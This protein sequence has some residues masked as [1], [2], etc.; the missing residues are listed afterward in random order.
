M[1][2]QDLRYPNRHRTFQVCFMTTSVPVQGVRQVPYLF[3]GG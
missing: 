3:R 2:V 1:D